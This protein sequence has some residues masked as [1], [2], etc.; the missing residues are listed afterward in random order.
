MLSKQFTFLLIYTLTLSNTGL[1]SSRCQK[2]FSVTQDYSHDVVVED[3]IEFW[4]E[5]NRRAK[6]QQKTHPNTARHFSVH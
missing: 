5:L 1:A 4:A 6:L 3:P 2:I